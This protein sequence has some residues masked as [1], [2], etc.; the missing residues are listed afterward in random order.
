M[1]ENIGGRDKLVQGVELL[2]VEDGVHVDLLPGYNDQLLNR[3]GKYHWDDVIH[4]RVDIPFM[5]PEIFPAFLLPNDQAIFCWR[6][7]FGRSLVPFPD[8]WHGML[9]QESS[10]VFLMDLNTRGITRIAHSN[11][12]VVVADRK[13]FGT[14]LEWNGMGVGHER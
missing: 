13:D 6:P 4:L 9:G 3:L 2:N 7:C 5:E 1:L 8:K 11:S 10:Q 12:I 14:D